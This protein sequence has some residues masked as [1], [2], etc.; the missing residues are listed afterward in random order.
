MAE[1]LKSLF[2]D[3][4][5]IKCQAHLFTSLFFKSFNNVFQLD[6]HPLSH[7]LVFTAQGEKERLYYVEAKKGEEIE[8]KTQVG[9]EGGVSQSGKL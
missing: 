1:R 7:L 2:F 9:G 4:E 8:K 3:V 6:S 5:L